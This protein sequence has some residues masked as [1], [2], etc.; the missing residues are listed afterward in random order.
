M[1]ATLIALSV[2]GLGLAFWARH[3]PTYEASSV[4][5]VSPNFPA[6]FSTSQEQEYPYDSFIEEQ[7][8]SV[9]GYNV[10]TDALRRLKPG[11]WQY[12]GE[13]VESAVDRLQHLLTVKRDGL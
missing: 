3:R 13:T 5:Y 4:V 12:P 6:T 11:V 10:L 7:I 1:L 9:A 8:H 2:I